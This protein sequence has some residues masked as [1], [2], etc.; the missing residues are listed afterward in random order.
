MISYNMSAYNQG[1][2]VFSEL[3]EHV[4]SGLSSI[5]KQLSSKFFYDDRGSKIFQE[6]MQLPEYYLTRA[7]DKILRE[8]SEAIYE[9][10]D[11]SHPFNVV[12]L[13]AGDGSKTLHLLSHLLDE[14][15]EFTYCP[16][17][18]SRQAIVDLS[19]KLEK[20]LPYLDIQPYVGDY[21]QM[22]GEVFTANRPTL[23]LFLGSNIGNFENA[24]AIKMLS[25]VGNE[26]RKK[27][28]LLIGVDLKKNPN[29]I[30]RAYFD[31]R[32]V[33]AEFNLNLL[34]RINRELHADFREDQF[35]FYSHY[36]PVT[37]DVRSYLISMVDQVVTIP[38]LDQNFSFKENEVIRTELSKKYSLQDVE[39]LG[40]NS[41]FSVVKNF[42]DPNAYFTDSLWVK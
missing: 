23:V 34:R 14:Q 29:I 33:T 7:E 10:L 18:I 31:E 3:A 21:F 24:A 25:L 38:D 22:L 8:Q 26:L 32:R 41:G 16:I 20:H 6:I 11:F 1:T 15:I 17:D 30:R 27:D 4:C 2:Q 19:V 13:G 5:P 28:K 9:H 12:E 35:D 39:A 36:D 37:G 40:K 42:L